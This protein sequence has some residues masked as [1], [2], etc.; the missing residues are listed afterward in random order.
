MLEGSKRNQV[1]LE[2]RDLESTEIGQVVQL[3]AL[4]ITNQQ[5]VKK[6]RKQTLNGLSLTLKHRDRDSSVMLWLMSKSLET[7]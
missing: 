1:G 3:K 6:K 2:Q 4:L 7:K 5:Q